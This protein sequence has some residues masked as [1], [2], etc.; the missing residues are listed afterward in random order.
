MEITIIIE[1]FENFLHA[2]NMVVPLGA[3]SIEVDFSKLSKYNPE[4]ANE[5]LDN[6]EDTLR[7]FS[8]ATARY[9]NDKEIPVRIKNPPNSQKILI[10]EIRGEKHY[11]KLTQLEG[12]VKSKSKVRQKIVSARYECPA[13]NNTMTVL[14]LGDEVKEPKM[15]GCGRKG[16]FRLLSSDRTNVFVISLQEPE[17]LVKVGSDLQNITCLFTHDLCEYEKEQTIYQGC[18]IKL[19]GII[20]DKF[21][22]NR[23]GSKNAVLDH[24]FEVNQVEEV[25]GDLNNMQ[26]TAEDI[27]Q[28]KDYATQADCLDILANTIFAPIYGHDDVKKAIILSMISGT[29]FTEKHL[30]N[31]GL[32]HTLLIGDPACQPAGSKVLMANGE[33]KNIEDIREGDEILSPQKD[34][35]YTYSTVQETHQWYCNEMYDVINNKDKKVYACTYNHKIPLI[36]KIIRKNRKIMWSITD[37]EA[38]NINILDRTT[39][40]LSKKNTFKHRKVLLRK[41]S[42]AMVYGFTLNSPSQWYVTDNYMITHNSSKTDLMLLAGKY[43]PKA[44]YINVAG[45]SSTSVGLTSNVVKDELTGEWTFEAG[46]IPLMHHGILMVDEIGELEEPQALQESLENM[47]VTVNKANIHACYSEDTEV[48]TNRGWLT[49]NKIRKSDLVAQY[50]SN[51]KVIEFVKGQKVVYNYHGP[52]I[53]F[54]SHCVDVLVTPEHRMW[55]YEGSNVYRYFEDFKFV[56]AENII[57]KRFSFL[58]SSLNSDKKDVDKEYVL[59]KISYNQKRIAYKY[60]KNMSETRVPI[61]LWMQFIGYYLSEG[62]LGVKCGI[63]NNSFP[64]MFVQK[65][66]TN[67]SNKMELCFT[68]I[69]SILNCKLSKMRDRTYTRWSISN[70]QLWSELY[71]NYGTYCN[72]KHIKKELFNQSKEN[73]EELFLSL[74]EGDGSKRKCGEFSGYATTSKELADDIQTLCLLLGKTASIRKHKPKRENRKSLYT[75]CITNTCYRT[76]YN[77]HIKREEYNGK[78]FC[79]TVEPWGLFVT[80][81]N[82]KI[83]IQGNSLLAETTVLAACNPKLGRFDPYTNV[84]EQINMPPQMISRFDLIYPFRDVLNEDKDQKIAD[85]ILSR[86]I[87][88]RALVEESILTPDLVKKWIIMAQKIVPEMTDE[89]ADFMKEKYVSI[90]NRNKKT[91]TDEERYKAVP[92]SARQLQA[93]IRLSQALTKLQ[94]RDK[95]TKKNA[96]FAVNLVISSLELIGVDPETGEMDIQMLETGMPASKKNKIAHVTD[97]FYH[98]DKSSSISFDDIA[99]TVGEHGISEGE[100]EEILAKLKTVG[101]IYEPKAGYW[102]KI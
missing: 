57:C 89:V 6:A 55:V 52:M 60:V 67:I 65:T 7:A 66:G 101:S 11:N 22:I 25:E 75:L 24:F 76:L 12:R 38:Q 13:C 80:R 33:W 84:F 102:R 51:D 59:P 86:H 9:N 56:T 78:V 99:K 49:H 83:T 95:I 58:T 71:N 47:S 35:T 14:I 37:V 48:L 16:K 28:I 72:N 29:T 100:V 96:E 68:K 88:R 62:G 1:E 54:K 20:K 23:D 90:R 5:L 64:I 42:P 21:K 82:G 63:Y 45:G 73:L 15:C 94:L 4:I 81:R 87:K 3:Q 93:M 8:I 46:A 2:Q 74:M 30:K 50:N 34:G 77:H 61:K 32:I 40:Q 31:R 26:I 41:T 98:M 69:A 39:I 79:F 97:I 19:N 53:N 85:K 10:R 43:H 44:M 92:I 36:H 91:K 70:K 18:R 27:R 17:D